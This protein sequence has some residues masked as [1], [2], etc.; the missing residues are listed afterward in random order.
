MTA[1]HL[2]NINIAITRAVHQAGR[3]ARLLESLGASVFHYPCIDIVPPRDT[4]SLDAALRAVVTGG[5]Q[6]MVLTSTNTINIL[7]QRM[8]ALDIQASQFK[9]LKI[10]TIGSVTQEA[11]ETMLGLSADLVPEK[12][13]AESL[14]ASMQVQSGDKIFLPQSEIARPTLAEALRSAGAALTTVTAYH[15]VVASGGDPVPVMLWEGK[16]D[17]ITFTS[18]STVRYFSHR[19]T[20]EGGTLDM[21]DDVCVACIGP[22]TTKAARQFG[23]TVDAMP[24]THTV[25]GLV[26]SLVDYFKT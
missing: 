2:N 6:W 14:A 12:F 15:N 10:A 20:Q 25:D 13:V 5:F 16:I 26:D 24:E 1:N 3:Q 21:L 22:V 4:T 11:V 9:Q 18:E 7:A 23:L 8:A 17:A 19:I